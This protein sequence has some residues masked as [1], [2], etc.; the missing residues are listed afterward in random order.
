MFPSFE[1]VGAIVF[2]NKFQMVDSLK[3]ND[4]FFG[5]NFLSYPEFCLQNVQILSQLLHF[6]LM[7]RLE[8]L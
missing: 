1:Y 6:L 3:S 5:I 2:K 7:G 4:F 8:L